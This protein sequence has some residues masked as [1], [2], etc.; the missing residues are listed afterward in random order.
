MVQLS[1][2]PVDQVLLL[3]FTPAFA[4][5]TA[6]DFIRTVLVEGLQLR[7]L[8]VGDDFHFGQGRQ[9]D[10]PMLQKAGARDGFEV[11][12]THSFRIGEQR[13][14]STYIR[15]ALRQGDLKLA[16]AL[17][18]RTYSICGRVVYGHQR[19]RSIGFPTANVRLFRHASPL[20]GVYA[21]EMSGVGD[22]RLHGVANVGVRP[23]VDGG[24]NVLLETH[25]FDFD[26]DIYGRY[27]EVHFIEKIRDEQSFDNFDALKEQ[28][29][30]DVESARRI[31][32]R[33]RV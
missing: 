16:Q 15:Q 23:T 30:L 22:Q 12:D 4:R 27:V 25:L 19:G 26:G 18:G 20:L 21:V 17:L 32:L 5:L 33:E 28:I 13:V 1:L 31:H 24:V 8:V 6:N 14:S 9:G 11:D 2:L 29:A 3:R 10:F 7:Y